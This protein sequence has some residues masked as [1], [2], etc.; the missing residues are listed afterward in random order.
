[1]SDMEGNLQYMLIWVDTVA[2]DYMIVHDSH[3]GQVSA[4]V[5]SDLQLSLVEAQDE[6]KALDDVE[7][8][9]EVK[10]AI[11]SHCLILHINVVHKVFDWT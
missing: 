6:V 4:S 7:V 5:V 11:E 8:Q 9:D 3:F 1:M 2:G 10:V